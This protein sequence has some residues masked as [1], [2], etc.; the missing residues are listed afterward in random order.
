LSNTDNQL[1]YIEAA[2][3]DHARGMS[4]DQW[5]L[6]VAQTRPPSDPATARASIAAK[7][8]QLLN[9]ERDHNG[10]VGSWAAAVAARAQPQQPE[11]PTR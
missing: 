4:E 10:P 5:R 2:L 3:R 8:G 9:V 11:Q 1:E 7:A 6:F